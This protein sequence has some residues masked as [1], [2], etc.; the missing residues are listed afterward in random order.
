MAKLSTLNAE[1]EDAK[2]P[3][4][5][6]KLKRSTVDRITKDLV[7]RAKAINAD[8]SLCCWVTKLALF[9][10]SIKG[11]ERPGDIDIA[12]QLA[13]KKV[14]DNVL[15]ACYG[16]AR[17]PWLG[18][19]RCCWPQAEVILKLKNRSKAISLHDFDELERLDDPTHMI[20]YE[21][22]PPK[23]KTK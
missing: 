10:S 14:P 13:N 4:K 12:Y 3:K 2:T 17:S 9:G 16:R 1:V 18:C 23:S 6:L 7:D 11:K 15:R 19:I 21:F 22:T 5:N 8:P 20:I